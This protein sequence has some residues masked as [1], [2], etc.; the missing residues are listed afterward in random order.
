MVRLVAVTGPGDFRTGVDGSGDSRCGSAP[1]SSPFG[2]ISDSPWCP[3]PGRFINA[4]EETNARIG[5][6]INPGAE[7]PSTRVRKPV[8]VRKSVNPGAESPTR[9]GNP[10]PGAETR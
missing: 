8:A 5:R 3:L 4:G 10:N 6:F 9:R 7:T 2:Q 1:R